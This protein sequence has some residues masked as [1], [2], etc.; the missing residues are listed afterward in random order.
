MFVKS[1]QKL[2]QLITGYQTNHGR[3]SDWLHSSVRFLQFLG[4]IFNIFQTS[5]ILLYF[6]PF[7]KQNIEII[8][9]YIYIY[10]YIQ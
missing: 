8:Y 3:T 9:I 2:L 1:M 10:I 7:L 4:Q 6:R 5:H